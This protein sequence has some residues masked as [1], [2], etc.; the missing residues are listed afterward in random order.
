MVSVS[1][2]NSSARSEDRPCVG[3]AAVLDNNSDDT[4]KELR[5][6][7]G[8]VAETAQ[9]FASA[10]RLARGKHLTDESIKEI[11]EACAVG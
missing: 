8:A 1:V 11:A 4:G 2:A 7:A 6:V 3:M 5:L 9:H 10:R